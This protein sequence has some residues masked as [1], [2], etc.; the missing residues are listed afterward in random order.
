M[1]CIPEELKK[2]RKAAVKTNGLPSSNNHDPSNIIRYNGLYYLWYTEHWAGYPYDHFDYCSIYCSTSAD[3]IN[4][5][6]GRSALEPSADGWD[7]G[8]V[9]TANVFYWQGMYYMWYIGVRRGYKGEPRDCS[10][11]RAKTLD[12]PF[13][14]FSDSPFLLHGPEGSWYDNS[15]DDVS[16]VFFKGKWLTYFKGVSYAKDDGDLSMLGLAFSDSPLGPYEF[17]DGNPIVRGHAFSIW[18][19]KNGLLLLSGLKD[20]EGEGYIYRGDWNDSRGHQYLY[21]SEDGI[22]FTPCAEFENR[23]S[24]IYIPEDS[25][26]E[27][28]G[29]Y[30]G[31]SVKSTNAHLGRYIERF[32]FVVE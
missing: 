5:S 7:N 22:S 2:V 25:R 21:Y 20:K 14:R 10:L 24:G 1:I 15:L 6:E 12:G 18:P 9:L 27:W 3:G 17:Y 30:W 4:W 11:A 23:A 13:E 16:S 29:N 32:D 28:I 31:V 8:G 26:K 19:Y